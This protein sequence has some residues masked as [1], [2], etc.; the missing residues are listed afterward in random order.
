MKMHRNNIVFIHLLFW[1]YIINQGLFPLYTGQLE[2][3]YLAGNKFL[4]DVCLKTILNMISFYL[5]YFSFPYL[6][7][8]KNLAL[9]LSVGIPIVAMVTVFRTFIEFLFWKQLTDLPS[10]ELMFKWGYTWNNLRLVIITGIYAILIRFTINWFESQ[11][12][13]NELINRQ[14]AS[15]L[16]LLRSRINPHFLFNTLNNI[17]SLVY[18]KSDEAP[19]AVMKL[20]SIMRYM[21][22]DASTKKVLLEEEVEHLHSFIEL[23]KLRIKDPY[24]VL[25][26]IDGE[27]ERHSIEPMLLIPFVENAF[28]YGSRKHSPGIVI[29]LS[30][31]RKTIRFEV[32]N[33]LKKTSATQD[34]DGSRSD[35][36][37]IR[38]RL[39]LIYP[40][41]HSLLIA[42]DSETYRIILEI[43]N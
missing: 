37:N 29:R 36:V 11:K 6:L 19:A 24:F 34:E 4:I 28:R 32:L 27:T 12:L 16:A 41:K 23:Q 38:R 18:R 3:V 39:D 20:S 10:E 26:E 25:F 21:L 7:K 9:T 2:E 14:Q 35:L 1:F 33:Y 5:I 43:N 31:T 42:R 8:F 30:V 40:G 22:S 15:E 17:Y 13:K